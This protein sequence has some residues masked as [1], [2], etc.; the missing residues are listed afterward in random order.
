M[1]AEYE[2]DLTRCENSAHSRAP[3]SA[4]VSFGVSIR[5]VVAFCNIMATISSRD[6]IHESVENH[7]AIKL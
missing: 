2:R 7:E 5:D 4:D 1:R 6:R 3:G